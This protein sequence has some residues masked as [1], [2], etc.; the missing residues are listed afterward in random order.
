MRLSMRARAPLVALCLFLVTP[1]AARSSDGRWNIWERTRLVHRAL[2]SKTLRSIERVLSGHGEEIDLLLVRAATI[3]L[4]R[5]LDQAPRTVVLLFHLRRQLGLSPAQGGVSRLGAVI[6]SELSHYDRALGLYELARLRLDPGWP[7][8]ERARPGGD[9]RQRSQVRQG[10]LEIEQGLL[11]LEQALIAAWEPSL[12]AEILMYRGMFLWCNERYAEARL[13]LMAT[14]DLVESGSALRDAYVALAM[15][16][17]VLENRASSERFWRSAIELD[18][19]VAR[20]AA[21]PPF[22]EL[23]LGRAER[24]TVDLSLRVGGQ[25]ERARAVPELDLDTC[26]RLR[27]NVEETL[28]PFSEVSRAWTQFCPDETGSAQ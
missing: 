23:P 19:R 1:R 9:E 21:L 27:V 25:F 4:M 26:D 16:E 6:S 24:S 7:Q 22:P 15:T 28:A 11:E 13:D 3:E 10:L 5:D 12:R 8:I 2:E 17:L 20:T 14:L 18:Q